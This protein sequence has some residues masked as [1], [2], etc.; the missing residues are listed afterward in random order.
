MPAVLSA[1]AW[2]IHEQLIVS[3]PNRRD[4][5]YS[6]NAPHHLPAEAGEVR[7]S[8]SGACG[9][10]ASRRLQKIV[11]RHT[12]RSLNNVLGALEDGLRDCQ[13]KCACR[14]LI[15]GNRDYVPTMP[16]RAQASD[17]F[18]AEDSGR[19]RSTEPTPRATVKLS[20]SYE[21][22]ASSALIQPA[23]SRS[24]SALTYVSLCF[25]AIRLSG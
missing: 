13:G 20:R 17:G 16:S 4:F 18:S 25:S 7:C 23:T 21:A 24:T 6:L 3:N 14:L 22:P 5:S 19:S 8:R 15:M 11:V 2:F 12:G 9:C 10:W 1:W